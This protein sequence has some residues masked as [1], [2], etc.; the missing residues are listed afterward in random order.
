MNTFYIEAAKAPEKNTGHIRLYNEDDFKGMRRVSQ[1]TAA[2][3]DELYDFIEPGLTTQAIDEFV[4]EFGRKHGAVPATLHYRGYGFSTCTSVN[5]VVCH[6]M[7][8]SRKLREGDIINVDVTFLLDG[9]HGD[10]SRTYGVGKIAGKANRLLNITYKSL[11]IGI[12]QAKPGNTTGDIGAAIQKYVEKNRC[13]VVRVFCGHGV[14]RLFHDAPNI[15]HYGKR[16]SGDV[17]KPG[18]IFT[19][20]PMVNFGHHDVKVLSDHW[21]A[22]T[23][24]GTL[25]AQFEHTVGITENGCEVFT[26]SPRGLD[27]P[28]VELE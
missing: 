4:F 2:C 22:V 1:L 27:K 5:E 15:L 11:L 26:K 17:L 6:G 3:L 14:G 16:K 25:S 13:S 28:P 24:D 23:R 10:S 9:W 21:T 7:P 8:D 19:I 12:E 20:E 18:M